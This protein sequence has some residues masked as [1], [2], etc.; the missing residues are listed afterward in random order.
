MKINVIASVI[1]IVFF[2]ISCNNESSNNPT[3]SDTLSKTDSSGSSSI[4]T[5]SEAPNPYDNVSDEPADT[6]ALTKKTVELVKS[7]LDNNILKK[8]LPPIDSSQRKFT[9][10]ET[11]LNGDGNNEIFVGFNGSYFCGSGGCAALLLDNKGKLITKFTV[12]EYP[13]NVASTSTKGWK[14]LI[15]T[16]SGSSATPHLVKWD[17]YKYPGNPTIQPK[18]SGSIGDD[19]IKVLKSPLHWY[20]F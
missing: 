4:K 20:K 17:G 10:S 6:S 1:V 15:I 18:Y 11:D 5:P 8:D 16:S 13:I 7:I 14:D 3:P 9:F 2:A 19:L 12:T